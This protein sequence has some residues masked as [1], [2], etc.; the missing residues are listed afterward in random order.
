M[1]LVYRLVVGYL[2]GLPF[3]I[4]L[5]VLLLPRLVTAML[6]PRRPAAMEA[7]QYGFLSFTLL[8]AALAGAAPFGLRAGLIVGAFAVPLYFL[9][10]RWPIGLVLTPR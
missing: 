4:L 1:F 5:L 2:D 7:V 9:L 8:E 10:R 3:A 6:D